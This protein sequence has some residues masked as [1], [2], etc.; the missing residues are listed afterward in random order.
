MKRVCYLGWLALLIP[1]G[2]VVAQEKRVM[3]HYMTD[4][5]P[6][7][8][9]SLIR[10]IDP[11]LADPAGSTGVLGGLQQTQPLASLYL[12][13]ADL[14]AAVD[15]EIR[16]ARQLGVDGFQFY[17]P[18]GDNTQ[19]L[20]GAYNRIIRTF[21]ERSDAHFP[22]FKVS[23]CLSH[24]GTS[25][26]TTEAHRVALWSRPIRQL[27]QS[28]RGST[29]WLRSPGG[30]LLFYLWVG[31]ALA[32][33]VSGLATT[34]AGIRAV[35]DAY[36]RLAQAVGTPI[37]YIYQVRRPVVDAEYVEAIA[38]TFTGVWGW[39]ASDEHPRF[40][41]YLARRCREEGCL[42]TQTVYPD[43]YTSKVYPKGDTSHTILSTEQ[44]LQKGLAGL[45]RYYR[46]TNLAQTQIQLLKRAVVHDVPLINYVTWNDF[47]EGHHLAPEV[48][49]NFGPALLL[50]HFKRRWKSGASSVQRDEAI[51][52]FKKYRHDVRP[53]YAVAL[54]I[55]SQNQNLADEDRIELV[56]LLTAP[57][58]CT[59]NGQPLGLVPAGLQVRSIP[60][61]PG[62][63][64]V[65][66]T[67]QGRSI[68]RFQTPQVISEKPL[69]TDRLT[70]SYS[71][72]FE[73]EFKTLFE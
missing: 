29:A 1:G 66:V 34:A 28:T 39:T 37:D 47:P 21:I 73:R 7:T 50:K 70:V 49:H 44:A 65:Q 41:D 30:G 12:R 60:S 14:V 40:W 11:E 69:R 71:S 3:A 45:Q 42:Y 9:R 58:R 5:V 33:G 67:R 43:Y 10:W 57:A 64:R 8:N 62:A 19:M 38:R 68:I 20:Q 55:K 31:D 54:K 48:N 53:R 35:G 27:V 15:F 16:A 26:P 32:D 63:V 56:T 36:R 25:R 13:G 72:A 6:Q 22:G 18:L 51:V 59:L 17:Y 52:F 61:Q 24:P 23:L 2:S 4:M 46:V